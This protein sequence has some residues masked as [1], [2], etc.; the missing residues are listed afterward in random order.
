MISLVR[1][2]V[3]TDDEFISVVC[4]SVFFL[5]LASWFVY[6]HFTCWRQAI[7][8][9]LLCASATTHKYIYMHILIYIILMYVCMYYTYAYIYILYI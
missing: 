8:K 4:S 6:K 3:C 1:V 5:L 2:T 9:C 7:R